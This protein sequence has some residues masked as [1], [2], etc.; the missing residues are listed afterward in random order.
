MRWPTS[1][2]RDGR[3]AT[4][5]RN[6][7]S[8]SRAAYLRVAHIYMLISIPTDTS[9]IFGAF[10]AILAL[11]LIPDE[12][13][14]A[15]SVPR[16][17]SRFEKRGPAGKQTRPLGQVKRRY[18]GRTEGSPPGLPGG[19]ITGV[20]PPSGVGA[21]ISGSTPAGGQSTPSDLASR[22]PRGSERW[23]VVCPSGAAA[24]ECGASRIGAQSTDRCGGGG[25]V[26]CAGVEGVGGACASARPG[27]A[28]STH[29]SSKDR[30]IGIRR[31]RSPRAR[32]PSKMP[33]DY[34][35]R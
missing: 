32:V 31:K 8:S 30:F 26:C 21:R 25:A 23:P 16:R 24:P 20:L 28:I 29:V 11:P 12:L 10:Q 13:A 35:L 7:G 17:G 2:I 14:G 1:G 9:T 34:D 6:F 3:I 15:G 4:L 5:K 22:S 33:R 19:G 27:A 18:F